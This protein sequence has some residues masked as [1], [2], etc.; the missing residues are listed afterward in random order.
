VTAQTHL[1]PGWED[2][3][4]A[5]LRGKPDPEKRRFLTAWARA[6]GGD[7]EWNPL[8][9]TFPLPWSTV[10][11]GN[12]DGVRNYPR[13]V[14]GVCATAMTLTTPANGKLTYPTLLARLQAPS[15]AHT[16]EQILADCRAELEHW[17][18]NPDL[19]LQILRSG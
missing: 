5:A 17:G 16:A 9:T 15:G 7:A 3:L 14:W 2:S 4:V 18:S 10:V 1:P 13:A 8:N 6:E 12:P 19:I 11:D